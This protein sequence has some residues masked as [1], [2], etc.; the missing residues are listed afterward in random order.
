[1]DLKEGP[2]PALAGDGQR[3][4]QGA[5]RVVKEIAVV[6]VLAVPPR[7]AEAEAADAPVGTALGHLPHLVQLVGP[8]RGRQAGDLQAE[9][10][11]DRDQL[12]AAGLQVVGGEVVS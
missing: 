1:V 2:D 3:S 7:R 11:A 9:L 12:L 8:H 6:P 10:P 5:D 4:L